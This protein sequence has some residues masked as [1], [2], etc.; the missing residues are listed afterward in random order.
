MLVLDGAET[1]RLADK[2]DVEVFLATLSQIS[3]LALVASFRGLTTP[4][5]VSWGKTIPVDNPLELADAREVFLRAAGN[6]EFRQDPSLDP[7]LEAVGRVPLAIVLIARAAQ[8]FRSLWVVLDRWR[9]HHLW[10]L[11]DLDA[12]LSLS[13]DSLRRMTDRKGMADKVEAARRLLQLLGVLPNGIAREE[14]NAILPPDCGYAAETILLGAALAFQDSDRL[15]VRAP[16]RESVAHCKPP[17]PDDLKRLIKHFV[18]MAKTYGSWLGT[19]KGADAVEKL[20]DEI[21]NLEAILLKGLEL[22][23]LELLDPAP[24]ID[25]AVDVAAVILYSGLGTTEVL[26]KA[27]N[28]AERCGDVLRQAHCIRQMG[29]V[30]QLRCEYPKAREYYQKAFDIYRRK[31]NIVYMALC[32]QSMGNTELLITNYS[33]ASDYFHEAK[34]LYAEANYTAGEAN[35]TKLDS[36]PFYAPSSRAR[37]AIARSRCDS[38]KLPSLA[39]AS[40]PSGGLMAPELAH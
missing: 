33:A 10:S 38:L 2:D 34:R 32:K 31:N 3:G 17:G 20:G 4:G 15:L 28:V 13:F 37:S 40:G 27:C 5:K 21:A 18:T 8:P 9:D 16:V 30:V 22:K 26:E 29:D 7:L 12:S 36:C 14:L 24:S 35:S 25:A 19:W 6:R 23:G 1:P 39:S 11:Q